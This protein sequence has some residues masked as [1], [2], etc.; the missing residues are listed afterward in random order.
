MSKG[1]NSTFLF[2]RD[3]MDY[4]SNRFK[5][6]SLLIFRNNNLIGLL[7]AHHSENVLF[8]HQ[9][10][11]YGGI[12]QCSEIP[13]TEMAV[14]LKALKVY[15]K[16]LSISFFEY[17]TIPSFYYRSSKKILEHLNSSAFKVVKK[18]KVL[19]LDFADYQIH[20]TKLKHYR[21]GLSLGLEIRMDHDFDSFW[22]KLL[23]P[24]LFKKY[25]SVPVHTLQEIQLLHSRFPEQILQFNA[26][27]NNELVAGLTIFDKGNVVKS[28]YAAT[29]LKGEKCYAIDVL[30]LHLIAYYK[31]QGKLYFSMGTV[32]TKDK[33]GYNP[34]LLRQKQELGCQIYDQYVYRV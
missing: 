20:K 24:R 4:H 15:L 33:L 21:K 1:I 9:G 23:V 28:Q 6:H 25:Q 12:I 30:F 3:F 19:A 13:K 18:N 10:L 7:P 17:K 22:N 32:S 29:C 8:S 2:D 14:L 5:D 16:T 34:G 27:L 11:T 26:Y 31:T